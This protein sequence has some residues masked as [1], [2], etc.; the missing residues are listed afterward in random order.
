MTESTISNCWRWGKGSANQWVTEV[1][2][3]QPICPVK[4]RLWG[5]EWCGSSYLWD[6]EWWVMWEQLSNRTQSSGQ[7]SLG[8]RHSKLA[9]KASVRRSHQNFHWTNWEKKSRIRETKHLSTDADSSTD[10]IGGWTKNTPKPDFFENGKNHQKRKHSEMSRNMTKLA[11][12]PL[13]RG[14]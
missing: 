11:I 6:Y 14:P 9:R 8:Q 4:S 1:F 13:T 3:E 12:R 2:V 7:L 10:A 5:Y